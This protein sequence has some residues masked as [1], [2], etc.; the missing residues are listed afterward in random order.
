MR[1]V[2]SR[3]LQPTSGWLLS[4]HTPNF[5]RTGLLEAFLCPKSKNGFWVGFCVI[6]TRITIF[7][8]RCYPFSGR[9]PFSHKRRVC[10]HAVRMVR[11]IFCRAITDKIPVTVHAVL[12]AVFPKDFDGWPLAQAIREEGT[13]DMIP[14]AVPYLIRVKLIH[15]K[16]PSTIGPD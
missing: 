4:H 10:S 14:L 9:F 12:Q 6:T 1:F 8:K 13:F 16:A 3:D 11:A 15:P 5:Q 2:S 7:F